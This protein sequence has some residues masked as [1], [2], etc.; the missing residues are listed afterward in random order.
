MK[1]NAQHYFDNAIMPT[2]DNAE[3]CFAIHY[4]FYLCRNKKRKC[5]TILSPA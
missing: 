2:A 3:E 5:N 4:Y 1:W